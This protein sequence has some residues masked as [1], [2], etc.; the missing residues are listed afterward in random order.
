MNLDYSSLYLNEILIDLNLRYD[1]QISIDSELSS[2]CSV[3]IE[4][5]YASIDE[6]MQALA[7]YCG[8]SLS[9]VA[10][11]YVFSK[12]RQV[13]QQIVDPI[14]KH[15]W[16]LYQGTVVD[17]ETKEPLPY[18]KLM[19]GNA[20]LLTDDLG[21]FSVKSK[22]SSENIQVKYLGYYVLDSIIQQGSQIKIALRSSTLDLNVVEVH[23]QHIPKIENHNSG[24]SAG[25]LKFNEVSTNVVPGGGNNILFNY[26]RLYQGV[27]AAGESLSEYSVWGSYQGQ[28]QI[29]FDG[30][31]LFNS[32][33]LND[34]VGRVNPLMIKNIEVYK[35]G[36]NVE[37]GDRV[38]GVMLIDGKQG[39]RDSLVAKINAS[40]Q[41]T[42][43]YIGIPLFNNSSAL[44]IAGRVSYFE[45]FDRIF[46]KSISTNYLNTDYKYSDLNLKFSSN[47]KN[48]DYL[49]ISAM[50]SNDSYFENLNQAKA[51][52][53]ELDA[54][55]KSNQ[56]GSSLKYVHHWT[57][58]GFSTVAISNSNYKNVLNSKL[59]YLDSLNNAKYSLEDWQNGITEVSSKVTHQFS[60]QKNHKFKLSLGYVRSENKFLSSNNL[61][62]LNDNSNSLNRLS[63]FTQD[64]IQFGQRFNALLGF[65]VDLPFSSSLKPYF[66]P[67]INTQLKINDKFNWNVGWGIYNQFIGQTMTV[68]QYR[69]INTVW[70]VY[71]QDESPV[72]SSTHRVTGFSYLSEKVD[73]GVEGFYINTDGI[74]RIIEK[75]DTTVLFDQGKSRAYGGDFYMKYRI[76]KHELWAAYTLSRVEEQFPVFTQN[77]YKSSLHNQ[78]HE[79]KLAGTF[80]FHPFY[81]STTHVFG[82]GFNN[83]FQSVKNNNSYNR[84]DIA[85]QYRF[86]TKRSKFQ[87][88]FSILNLLNNNNFRL[89]QFANFPD[90][91]SNSVIGT[92]FT[93]TIYFNIIL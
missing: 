55:A 71:G 66:Q 83:S 39:T 17:F 21:Q 70:L 43:G 36:Y 13:E 74:S 76:K 92:P 48:G 85:F 47:L 78:L 27:L 31:T 82:S 28:N 69:N 24:E 26:I 2:V 3:T 8:L 19:V 63:M 62:E 7:N 46:S 51:S 87:T 29:V 80:N 50:Y 72:L 79:L 20:Q 41:I 84:T 42:N 81:I 30:V 18:A 73:L 93:A 9:K 67:R 15:E 91:G 40:T 60:T 56:F 58:G 4:K 23:M 89:Y 45:F 77:Y 22:E 90:G 65:K 5:D 54:V 38:G 86:R 32:A 35:A 37:V 57:K 10:K 14:I 11:V 34:N 75:N 33:G 59:T 68:N 64:K 53:K 1:L 6:A 52:D 16:F 25:H 61:F 44:Q 88:G 12:G 49:Q